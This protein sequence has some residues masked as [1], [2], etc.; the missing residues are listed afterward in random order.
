M[1]ISDFEY[2]GLTLETF[3]YTVCSFSSTDEETIPSPSNITFNTISMNFGT[4]NYLTSAPYTEALTAKFQICKN[5]CTNEELKITDEEIR[6][7]TRWLQ[8]KEFKEIRLIDLDNNDYFTN[9]SFNVSCIYYNDICYGFEIELQTNKPYLYAETVEVNFDISNSG[10]SYIMVDESD[11]IDMITPYV[12]IK[13]TAGN[14]GDLKIQNSFTG[15]ETVIK[16]CQSEE[17]ITFDYPAIKSSLENS[18]KIANDFNW[19]FL[20]IGNTYFDRENQLTFSIPC[21]VKIKYS[22]SVKLGLQGG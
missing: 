8:R 13:I 4:R 12:E 15:N 20:R 1:K 21:S 2:D 16:N 14:S 6:E 19:E 22:P 9:G 11:D 18:H 3:G 17:I 7:I 10:E 5:T